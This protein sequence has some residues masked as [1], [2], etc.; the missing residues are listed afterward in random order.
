VQVIGIG[1][2]RLLVQIGTC[3]DIGTY[4]YRLV[5]VVTSYL[6]LTFIFQGSLM[7]QG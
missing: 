4:W 7:G 6:H 1:C 5:Q 3:C 2:D